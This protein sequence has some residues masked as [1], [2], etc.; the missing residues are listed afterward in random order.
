MPPDLEALATVIGD[1]AR[2]LVGAP[3]LG[4]H[5]DRKVERYVEES[6]MSTGWLS[7]EWWNGD[8]MRLLRERFESRTGP[9]GTDLYVCRRLRR[10]DR[11]D[12]RILKC[13][14]PRD[15]GVDECGEV[16]VAVCDDDFSR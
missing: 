10:R 11:G 2:E 8:G 14:A 13:A 9:E 3:L 6:G 16:R 15:V 5:D 4:Q 12:E 7:A 1:A